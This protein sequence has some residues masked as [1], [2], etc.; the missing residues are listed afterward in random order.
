MLD[1][2]GNVIKEAGEFRNMIEA[3]H[4][5]KT[6]LDRIEALLVDILCVLNM[7]HYIRPKAERE[8]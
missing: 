3:R 6:Q 2:I 5:D 7:E 4:S 8:E 1:R